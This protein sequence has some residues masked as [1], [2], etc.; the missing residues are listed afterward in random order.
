MAV[1]AILTTAALWLR[2]LLPGTLATSLGLVVLL[3]I[4]GNGALGTERTFVVSGHVTGLRLTLSG[5]AQSWFFDRATLCTPRTA[6]AR[7]SLGVASD[8]PGGGLCD[9]R[10][11]AAAEPGPQTLQWSDGTVLDLRMAAADRFEIRVA[12]GA[13]RH[14]DGLLVLVGRPDWDASGALTFTGTARFGQDMATGNRA[15]VLSGRYEVRE[16]EF[17]RRLANRLA[18]GG[19]TTAGR[20]VV[21]TDGE[22]VQG[23]VAQV[24]AQGDGTPVPGFGH[25]MPLAEDGVRGFRAVYVSQPGDH[26]LELRSFGAADPV[27]LRPS[28]LDTATTSPTLLAL[29]IFIP[30]LTNAMQML[31]PLR[32]KPS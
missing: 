4:A 6:P 5:D 1:R 27:R 10:R 8:P 9:P 14:P 13:D 3:V 31:E 29:V 12:A 21:V 17:L 16:T 22:L 23:D 32:R 24:V 25:V 30:L 2:R 28:W 26:A 7:A 18:A 19:G 15:T 11:F 20:S